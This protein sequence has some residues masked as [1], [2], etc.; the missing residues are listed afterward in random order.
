ML[1]LVRGFSQFGLELLYLDYVESNGDFAA[2][3]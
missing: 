1:K 2:I 3:G